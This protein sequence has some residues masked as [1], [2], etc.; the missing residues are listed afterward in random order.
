VILVNL[1][2]KTRRYLMLGVAIG[3]SSLKSR[4]RSYDAVTIPSRAVTDSFLRRIE[5][6]PAAIQIPSW[7]VLVVEDDP[8][9]QLGLERALV[10]YPQLSIVEMQDDGYL[11]V[12][13]ALKHRPDLILMDIGLPGLDGIEATQQIK[14][15]LPS[16]KT[17]MFTSHSSR[18]E[19]MA[20][21]SSGA[22]AYCIK[23][24]RIEILLTAIATVSQGGVYIDAKVAQTIV[25]ELSAPAPEP[26]A[27]TFAALSE[28]EMEVLQL[29]VE[30]MS[31]PEIAKQLYISPNTVKA[32]VRGLMNKLV[33]SD[34][35]QVAV[36]ALRAGL[37]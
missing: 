17:I 23:G 21:F 9:V 12:E 36:K 33:A 27:E 32:H 3:T 25:A 16:V 4:D 24:S 26:D 14:A 28:R 11:A 15:Q 2:F 18:M 7:R 34:R 29:L 10:T 20:A 13:A 22:D 35:V 31:N 8:L 6:M 30:G 5:I 37:V 19:V 1:W